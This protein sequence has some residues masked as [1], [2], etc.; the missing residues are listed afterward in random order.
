MKVCMHMA[1]GIECN[2]IKSLMKH[3]SVS[4]GKYQIFC[5]VI[6]IKDWS[7]GECM[8]IVDHIDCTCQRD[9]HVYDWQTSKKEG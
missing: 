3:H 5:Q 8:H 1:E 2:C 7:L 9:L 6:E 4:C